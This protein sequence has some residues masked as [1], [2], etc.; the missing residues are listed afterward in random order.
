MSL[1]Q[2]LRREHF[3][4]SGLLWLLTPEARRDV[5]GTDTSHAVE[6]HI[7]RLSCQDAGEGEQ[8]R[9][10][11]T[12]ERGVEVTMD[13]GCYSAVIVAGELVKGRGETFELDSGPDTGLERRCQH[14]N[15]IQL[16]SRPFF[17]GVAQLV[18]GRLPYREKYTKSMSTLY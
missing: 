11:E 1:V 14:Y 2:R 10:R 15:V 7:G 5:D 12:E 8:A 6:K 16:R 4:D 3:I 13:N 18:L 9:V 17:C